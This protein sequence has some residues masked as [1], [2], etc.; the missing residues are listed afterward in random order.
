ML[1][2]WMY[3]SSNIP[4]NEYM[5]ATY[6]YTDIPG[7]VSTLNPTTEEL[8]KAYS[9]VNPGIVSAVCAPYRASLTPYQQELLGGI[10]PTREYF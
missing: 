3:T 1:V 2:M 4:E 8:Y 9:E 10:L 7:P 5:F 6:K